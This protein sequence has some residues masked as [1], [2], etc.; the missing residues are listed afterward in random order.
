[1]SAQQATL[2]A[3]APK[4]KRKHHCHATGCTGAVRPELL[5][6]KDHWQVVPRTIQIAV[7]QNYRPGQCDDLMPSKG[8]CRAARLAV[9]AVA[10]LE[11]RLP[12]TRL[13]DNY[14]REEAVK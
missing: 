10:R 6:C 8:Y 1:M 4:K 13:Y 9:I 14:L 5:M 11:G 3:S 12:D 7:R 2:F